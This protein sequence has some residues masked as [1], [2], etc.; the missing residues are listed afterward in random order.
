MRQ[1]FRAGRSRQLAGPWS[2]RLPHFRADVRPGNGDEIQ[3]EY[4]VARRHGPASL[5]GV[6]R[7]APLVT[8]LLPVTGIRTTAA[9]GL[10]LSGSYD[11]QTLA[12]HFTWRN[13][14]DPVDGAVREA[15]AALAPFVSGRTG[16]SLAPH[17]R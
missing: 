12:I 9:D 17:G 1:Q 3:P 2:Q 15:E 5:D 11:R 14:P 7:P 10:W 6:R 13:R 8:P 16:E 4:F